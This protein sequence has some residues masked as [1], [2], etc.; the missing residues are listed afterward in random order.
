ML[1]KHTVKKSTPSDVIEHAPQFKTIKS[2]VATPCN[3]NSYEIQVLYV[4]Q[5][6]MIWFNGNNFLYILPGIFV[7]DK[8]F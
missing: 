6:Q 2:T 8:A 1:P 5:F 3:L 4:C 7:L